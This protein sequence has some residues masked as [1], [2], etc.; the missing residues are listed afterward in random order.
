MTLRRNKPLVAD[1]C[2]TQCGLVVVSHAELARSALGGIA[3]EMLRLHTLHM[4][5]FVNRREIM[6]G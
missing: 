3:G 5:S 1:F 6:V 4:I 2:A